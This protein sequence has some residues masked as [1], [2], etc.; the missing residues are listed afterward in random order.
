VLSSCRPYHLLDS[1]LTTK[2]FSLV[3]ITKA[4]KKS[5]IV[6]CQAYANGNKQHGQSQGTRHSEK[7]RGAGDDYVQKHKEDE[8]KSP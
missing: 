5:R 8:K 2:W 4:Q 3:S 6:Q 1:S 7:K